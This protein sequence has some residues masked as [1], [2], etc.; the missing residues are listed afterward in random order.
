MPESAPKVLHSFI[1]KYCICSNSH[2]IISALLRKFSFFFFRPSFPPSLHLSPS[3][4]HLSLCFLFMV[5]QERAWLAQNKTKLNQ[6]K[7]VGQTATGKVPQ[8][9]KASQG[10]NTTLS[11]LSPFASL[12]LKD[13]LW[14]DQ[15]PFS[16]FLYQ[17]QKAIKPRDL[18]TVWFQNMDCSIFGCWRLLFPLENTSRFYPHMRRQKFRH[19]CVTREPHKC[20]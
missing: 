4:L 1:S 14:S 9:N 8:E 11:V 7:A 20:C 6:R 16:S 2:F 3:F 15:S 10:M 18:Y 19:H 5:T 17:Q 12:L 13:G